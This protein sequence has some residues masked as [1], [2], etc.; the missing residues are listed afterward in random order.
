MRFASVYRQFQDVE[1]FHEEIKRLRSARA[2]PAAS[3]HARAHK[4]AGGRAVN[5]EQ[6]PLLPA[7]EPADDQR[8]SG[9]KK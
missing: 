1:A 3:A 4:R 8:G 2:A 7:E 6:L 5:R 9:G